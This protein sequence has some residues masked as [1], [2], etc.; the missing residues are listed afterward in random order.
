ISSCR[1]ASASPLLKAVWT[2]Y[3]AC[4]TSLATS[5]LA[6]AAAKAPEVTISRVHSPMNGPPSEKVSDH[7]FGSDISY[8][9][10]GGNQ[11]IAGDSLTCSGLGLGESGPKPTAR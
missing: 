6:P 9:P 8:R 10:K 3:L 5:S 7:W 11:L 1:T 2:A 4:S